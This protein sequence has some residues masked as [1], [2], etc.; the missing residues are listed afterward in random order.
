MD[1]HLI[2]FDISALR[3]SYAKNRLNPSDVIREAYRRISKYDNA[4]VWTELINEATALSSAR[5]LKP[6]TI[7]DLPL[8]GIPFSVKDNVNVAGM[9]TTCGCS[10]FNL[11]ATASAVGVEK[12]L[13][14]GA[15]LIGKNTLDQFATGLNGTRS[16]N[17]YCRNSF[18]QRYVPGGS[19]SGSGV[20][21]A[22]GLVSFSL[23]SDTGGSGRVP[24]AMN[25]VVG[26]KPT[27]GL[28]SSRGLIWNNRFFDCMPVLARNVDDGYTVLEC[29]RGHDPQDGF[30]RSDADSIPLASSIKKEF[31]FA[32]P[33]RNQLEFFGDPH[34]PAEFDQAVRHLEAIGGIACEF[35]FSIFIE[36]GKL[37]FDSGLL[38]E[39]AI[40]YGH[41]L[42]DDPESVHPSVA[43]L[44]RKGLSY[45]AAEVVQAIYRMRELRQIVATQLASVDVLVTPTVGR[46][47]T[48]NELESEPIVLNNNIGYYTYA[49]SPLDLCALAVPSSIRPDG[50]PFGIQ[51]IAPPGQDGVLH[52]LGRRYQDFVHLSPGI[53]AKCLA[54]RQAG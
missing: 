19:S 13:R 4:H 6:D 51:L 42:D 36:A 37:P 15:I 11:M 10:G 27:L 17:G 33:R 9:A 52:D 18:D 1:Q 20:A 44:L 31:R 16:L 47:Y 34:A 54:N 8:Y 23:G 24:A 41:I 48:C 29:I 30:S 39:R 53:E 32:V 40:S 26:V 50:L 12:A 22:A 35:D 46:A 14:A 43:A 21:V 28:V 25:N 3:Q 5:A 38:A 49:V 7:D 45:S 2:N